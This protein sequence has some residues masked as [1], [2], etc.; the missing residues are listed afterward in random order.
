MLVLHHVADP[1]KAL[2]E[3]ARVL[4]PGGRLLLVDMLPHDRESYRQ[5]MGHVW[6]GFSE[7]HIDAPARG[8]GFDRRANR[9]AA[10]GRACK[11]AR[12]VRRAPPESRTKRNVVATSAP[13]REAKG[14]R[15]RGWGPA[16]E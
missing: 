8:R 16:A 14:D 13:S 7:D 15:R 12:A 11:G 2:A 6:L 1:D 5:Q 3:A 9:R 4:K 10:A